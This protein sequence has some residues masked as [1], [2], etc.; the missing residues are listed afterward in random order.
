[1]RP[2]RKRFRSLLERERYRWPSST[3]DR[4]PVPVP[5]QWRGAYV[6][7]PYERGRPLL[8][9]RR[10]WSVVAWGPGANIA[11]WRP[12]LRN[13]RRQVHL[14]PASRRHPL[15]LACAPLNPLVRL[16]NTCSADGYV[17]LH[18]HRIPTRLWPP[19]KRLARLLGGHPSG[20]N[21]TTRGGAVPLHQQWRV[22]HLRASGRRGSDLLGQRWRPFV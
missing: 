12:V 2:P 15:L 19:P 11:V 5:E 8:G 22:A 13:S 9:Q 21:F 20:S 1:M 6:W 16:G 18:N 3:A 4:C 7:S 14:R 17:A 10:A